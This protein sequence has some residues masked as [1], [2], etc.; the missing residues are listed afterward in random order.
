MIETATS[1]SVASND[2]ANHAPEFAVDGLISN[3]Q[4]GFFMTDR[5]KYSWL[6]LHL[7]TPKRLIGIKIT[8]RTDMYIDGIRKMEIRAG[9]DPASGTMA[10]LTHN[11]KVGYYEGPAA[12]GETFTIMF[13]KTVLAKYVSIQMTYKL[14]GLSY[15]WLWVNEAVLIKGS[16]NLNPD[17][18]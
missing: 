18:S 3:T 14:V 13:D 1:S 17:Q 6:D 10:L 4:Y 2:L 11:E 8:S 5:L 15:G 9:M 16:K 7:A 12:Q